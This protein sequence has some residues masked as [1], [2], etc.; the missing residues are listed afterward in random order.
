MTLNNKSRI[1]LNAQLIAARSGE[2]NSLNWLIQ[3]YEPEIR[4]IAYKYFLNRAEYD[5]LLQE[6]RIGIYKAI[7]SYNPKSEIPFLHFVRMVIK[8]KIIDSLRAHNRQKHLNL[9]EAYSLNNVLTEGKIDSFISFVTT[10]DD[11]EQKV[12]EVD[13]TRI[14]LQEL[15]AGF[16]DLERKVFRYHFLIGMKQREITQHLG[17]G[18][19]S[20]DNT[21]QRIRRKVIAY[22]KRKL[23][24]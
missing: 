23:A 9:N 8:R 19:K 20:L 22:R 6:G 10:N 24:G 12:I 11:P 4:K 18:S 21:I 1:D 15:M 2:Q 3:Y 16:S 14:F 17:L 13:E 5:D 7:V